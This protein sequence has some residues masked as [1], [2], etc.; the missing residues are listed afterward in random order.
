[1]IAFVGF[2]DRLQGYQVEQL[3]TLDL[4]TRETTAIA[5]QLDR[6]VQNPVWSSDS[7]KVYFQYD[8]HGNTSLA[9]VDLSGK[10]Q[11]LVGDV[12]GMGGRP[13][14]GGSFSVDAKENI[15]FTK[16]TPNQPPDIVLLSKG[17]E[18]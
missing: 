18:K 13:Y 7:R 17:K 4:A 9:R 11:D 16:T 1:M 8:N 15:A 10:V 14:S 2:D 3:Y 6:D 12:G 5:E